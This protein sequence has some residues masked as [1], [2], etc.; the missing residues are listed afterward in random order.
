MSI[1]VQGVIRAVCGCLWFM[2]PTLDFF[3]TRIFFNGKKA[4][5][6]TTVCSFCLISL[7]LLLGSSDS[8]TS[9]DRFQNMLYIIVAYI[10]FSVCLVGHVQD[11][12]KNQ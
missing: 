9:D 10:S 11:E 6:A 5:Q 7:F 1:R 2:M 3:I 8:F 4:K 12:Y